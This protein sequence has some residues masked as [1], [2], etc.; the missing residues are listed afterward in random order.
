MLPCA[1]SVIDHSK[2]GEKQRRGTW[3]AGECVTEWHTHTAWMYVQ[4]GICARL[5]LF[6]VPNGTFCLVL[7]FVCILLVYSFF[8]FFFNSLT[9]WKQNNRKL[10]V[11]RKR[12]HNDWRLFWRF[13]AVYRQN[14]CCLRFDISSSLLIA[15]ANFLRGFHLLPPK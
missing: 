15:L 8:E 14:S 11:S 7:L 3:A 13:L 9:C 4:S 10:W 6:W 5:G 12:R 1:C 2:C